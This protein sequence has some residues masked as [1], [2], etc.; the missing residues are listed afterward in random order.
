MFSN[1]KLKAVATSISLL[2]LSGAAFAST[3][4]ILSEIDVNTAPSVA[5]DSNAALFYP[6]IS[7]DLREAIAE[8]VATSNN[9]ADPEVRVEIRKMALDGDTYLPDSMEFNELEGV[10]SVEAVDGDSGGLT[11][12]VTIVASADRPTVYGDVIFIPP[13]QGDF[14][15]AMVDAFA[16]AVARELALVNTSGTPISR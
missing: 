10:V 16:D 3:E 9:A 6:E 13:T 1:V 5:Q 4:L 8:R 2:A 14:Y 11:F 15:V 7:A 12:P